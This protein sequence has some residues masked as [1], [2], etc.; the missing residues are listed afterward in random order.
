[1]KSEVDAVNA[2]RPADPGILAMWTFKDSKMGQRIEGETIDSTTCF[3]HCHVVNP[4]HKGLY[5]REVK[6]QNNARNDKLH[7][8]PPRE[9]I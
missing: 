2:V 6:T 3:V 7:M 1:M 5:D 8:L 9:R 4:H